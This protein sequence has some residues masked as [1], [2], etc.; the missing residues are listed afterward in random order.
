MP[1]ANRRQM[2]K[3]IN[4]LL[5]E[6]DLAV[7]EALAKLLSGENYNVFTASSFE[8]ALANQRE[9]QIEV[10]LLDLQLGSEDGW[11][12][13]H[14]LRELDPNLPIIAASAQRDRLRQPVA[15][16]AT[17]ILE[18]PFDVALLLSLLGRAIPQRVAKPSSKLVSCAAA[19]ILGLIFPFM[20]SGVQS[21]LISDL[22]IQNENAIVTWQ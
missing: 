22:K 12:V 7:R 8:E 16:R 17:G 20:A 3:P 5:V 2:S 11:A 19:V 1:L 14:A 18:K 6:D 21:F 13:F 4:L 10:V 9:N 15:S